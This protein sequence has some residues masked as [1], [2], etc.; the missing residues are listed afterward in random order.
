[1]K[2]IEQGVHPVLYVRYREYWQSGA[3]ANDDL[4]RL[5]G[6]VRLLISQKFKYCVH[7][8]QG[9]STNDDYENTDLENQTML[10]RWG[11]I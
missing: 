6:P 4:Y 8:G 7:G 1:M 5:Y 3:P 10:L 11:L 2:A 9:L